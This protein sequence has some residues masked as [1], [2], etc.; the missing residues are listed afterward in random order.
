MTRPSRSTDVDRHR[1]RRR[2]SEGDVLF[3][4]STTC[5]HHCIL[6]V[7]LHHHRRLHLYLSCSYSVSLGRHRTSAS[8]LRRPHP[9]HRHRQR[10]GILLAGTGLLLEF[11]LYIH[12]RSVESSRV[13]ECTSTFLAASGCG[14]RPDRPSRLCA[15]R[16]SDGRGR[17]HLQSSRDETPKSRVDRGAM[18]GYVQPCVS[19]PARL[20]T[21]KNIYCSSR[22]V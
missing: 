3:Q 20:R 13:R 17:D 4:C 7:D 21:S 12:L 1:R 16:P 5:L 18:A 22:L 15:R 14:R 9:P 11:I 8:S 10:C 19:P 6:L 2:S